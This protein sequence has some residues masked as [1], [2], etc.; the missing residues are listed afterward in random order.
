MKIKELFNKDEPINISSI[1]NKYNIID[2]E[3]YLNPSGKYLESPMLYD[4]IQEAINVTKY[5]INLGSIIG[6]VVDVDFDGYGSASI[7]YRELKLLY[8]NC[9][10]DNYRW[11]ILWNKGVVV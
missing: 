1:L 9:V 11:C 10:I 8:P 3:E 7:L 5:H 4:N 2:I 6:I